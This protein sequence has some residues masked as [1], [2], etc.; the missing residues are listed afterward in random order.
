MMAT[1]NKTP[2][3][4]QPIFSS[5]DLAKEYRSPYIRASGDA[6]GEI[7]ARAAIG[8]EGHLRERTF[9]RVRRGRLTSAEEA[10]SVEFRQV[11]SP[12]CPDSAAVAL[13][14]LPPAQY[15]CRCRRLLPDPRTGA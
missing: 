13:T 10:R 7:V 5:K 12:A 4:P 14:K 8:K 3:R 11:W 9:G 6:F 1:L 2:T 15:V